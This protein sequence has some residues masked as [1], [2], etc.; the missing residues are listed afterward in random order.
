MFIKKILKELSIIA[1]KKKIN[2][3]VITGGRSAKELYKK[4]P[5]DS[6]FKLFKSAA[7]Y[8]SDERF[9]DFQSKDSI[10]KMINSSLGKFI[11]GNQIF[12]I[13][14]NNKN[15][16]SEAKSY[17]KIIPDKIDVVLLSVGE[18]GHVSSLFPKSEAL[19]CNSK[20]TYLTNSPKLPRKRL[21]ITPKII[22]N[23]RNV[24]VMAKGKKKGK[25][26]AQALSSPLEIEIL[27]VRLTIGRTWVLDHK[28]FCE[29]KKFNV[30]Q[31]YNTKIINSNAKK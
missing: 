6:S 9:V 12:K 30:K 18:D 16:K 28:A 8:L 19:K 7:F 4:W 11:P 23:A 1:N 2:S 21:T 25:L 24:L 3:I 20:V 26:L 5:N 15:F 13:N 27:P 14:G 22:L 10:Y 31:T 29:Y 17:N